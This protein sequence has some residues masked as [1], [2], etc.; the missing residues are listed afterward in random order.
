MTYRHTYLGRFQSHLKSHEA[1]VHGAEKPFQCDFCEKGFVYAYQLKTHLAA[2]A[3]KSIDKSPL[4]NRK[5]PKTQIAVDG[6]DNADLADGEPDTL[7]QCSL[8]QQVR[9]N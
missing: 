3:A 6:D 7:Y 8:C 5:G 1:T 2:H 9:D 4:K